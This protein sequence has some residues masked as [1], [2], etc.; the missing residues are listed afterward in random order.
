MLFNMVRRM[1]ILYTFLAISSEVIY[2][3]CALLEITDFIIY[4]DC[5]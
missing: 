1:L 2:C 5:W 3:I 4:Q